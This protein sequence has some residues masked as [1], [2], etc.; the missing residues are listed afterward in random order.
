MVGHRQLEKKTHRYHLCLNILNA[1]DGLLVLLCGL[2]VASL[3]IEFIPLT[4]QHWNCLQSF[5][6]IQSPGFPIVFS[7]LLHLHIHESISISFWTHFV[8][9]Y[10]AIITHFNLLNIWVK[11]SHPD[12]LQNKK[13]GSRFLHQLIQVIISKAVVRHHVSHATC[14]ELPVHWVFPLSYTSHTFRDKWID[15]SMLKTRT[16]LK[17]LF[18]LIHT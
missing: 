5:L 13:E 4:M 14:V 8:I 10:Y 12:Q 15:S 11:I 17:T 2:L 9:I 7:G 6:I 3:F 1:D 16:Y 18:L